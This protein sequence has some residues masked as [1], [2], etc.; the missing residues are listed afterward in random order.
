MLEEATEASTVRDAGRMAVIQAVKHHKI[1]R[2]GTLV[3]GAGALGVDDAVKLL[4]VTLGKEMVPNTIL[5]GPAVT[6]IG[7]WAKEAA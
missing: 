6:T 1:A 5:D 4:R 2:Y 3:A 7:E